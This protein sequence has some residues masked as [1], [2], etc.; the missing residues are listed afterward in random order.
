MPVLIAR[1]GYTGED[2]VEIISRAADAPAVWRL[3]LSF[4]E[5]TPCGLGARDTLRLEMGYHLYGNDMDCEID[6]IS[7]GL[8]WVCPK[9]ETGYTGAETVARI[10]EQGPSR[11]LVHL[12]VPGAIPRPGYAV[13][14]E[15][16]EVGKVAS[17]TF[18]P[19][20]QGGIATAYVPA[21][22]ASVG[23]EFEVV[24]RKK[25]ALAQVVKAPFVTSTSLSGQ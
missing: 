5:V 19:T 7:A 12:N 22:L 4:P 24:I 13:L 21:E 10:R 2:G 20:L 17:G 9:G 3:L 16:T 11:R 8:G 23:T 14:R 6:P 15:G 25:T 1:T 18:S